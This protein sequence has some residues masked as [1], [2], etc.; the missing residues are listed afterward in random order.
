M[1]RR[2][3]PSARRCTR[4]R[5]SSRPPATSP[6]SASSAI[7]ATGRS[8]AL[9]CLLTPVGIPWC[10]AA[11]TDPCI[12][13]GPRDARSHDGLN[14]PARAL[15]QP[16][17]GV[18]VEFATAAGADSACSLSLACPQSG[19]PIKVCLLPLAHRRQQAAPSCSQWP[20]ASLRKRRGPRASPSAWRRAAR[21]HP[22]SRRERVP[23]RAARIGAC[24][25]AAAPLA[26]S[27]SRGF[28]RGA[29]CLQVC[30]KRD[31]KRLERQRQANARFLAPYTRTAAPCLGYPTP[32]HPH[33]PTPPHPD[34]VAPAGMLPRLHLCA[35]CASG[36][37]QPTEG[38]L[39]GCQVRMP[40]R[41]RCQ[42]YMAGA[43]RCAA[44]H[45]QQCRLVLTG[46]VLL[47]QL[48]LRRSREEAPRQSKKQGALRSPPLPACLPACLPAGSVRQALSCSRRQRG[49]AGGGACGSAASCL[50]RSRGRGCGLRLADCCLCSAPNDKRAVWI[51]V[52]GLE[53][54]TT[55]Q[56]VQS[57]FSRYGTIKFVDVGAPPCHTAPAPTCTLLLAV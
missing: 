9:S 8:R 19:A 24:A 1:A 54:G 49:D 2:S 30:M 6:A 35:T 18:F 23:R 20:A 7:S 42:H 13:C 21:S 45:A 34:R 56:A 28:D 15:L 36:L 50:A 14:V 12:A 29:W 55:W 41:T 5:R 38:W 3:T 40:A 39:G 27:R 48:H 46:R 53:A 44:Q 25:P 43:R 51:R 52:S 17:G 31:W 16:T 47:A 11:R 26:I 32:S 37:T 10:F 33:T 4:C 57:A 22:I